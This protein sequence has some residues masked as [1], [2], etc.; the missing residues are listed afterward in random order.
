MEESGLLHAIKSISESLDRFCPII[1][2]VLQVMKPGFA[3]AGE[4]LN[5]ERR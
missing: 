3:G 1:R 4:M 2:F 5:F